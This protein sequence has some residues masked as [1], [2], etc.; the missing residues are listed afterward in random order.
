MLLERYAAWYVTH[1]GPV[2]EIPESQV[3][4]AVIYLLN[5]RDVNAGLEIVTYEMIK[6]CGCTSLKR[7]DRYMEPDSPTFFKLAKKERKK[8]A[9][10]LAYGGGLI[11]GTH[12]IYYKCTEE[13]ADGYAR[14]PA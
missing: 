9:T 8:G 6:D 4:Q 2:P 11:Y 13:Q 3:K 12:M 1:G 5:N 14:K 7:V 10:H